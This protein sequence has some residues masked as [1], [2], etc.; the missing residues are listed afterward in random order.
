MKLPLQAR[1]IL[2]IGGSLV[3][4]QLALAWL[5]TTALAESENLRRQTL[6]A[7][8][9]SALEQTAADT[10]QQHVKQLRLTTDLAQEQASETILVYEDEEQKPKR[11]FFGR[12]FGGRAQPETPSPDST[13]VRRLSSRISD[14]VEYRNATP[15][16]WLL[17]SASAETLPPALQS[18]ARELAGGTDEHTAQLVCAD[19]ACT[20]VSVLP[21]QTTDSVRIV[22]VATTPLDEI[23]GT[24][25]R[26]GG[27]R[28]SVAQP[29]AAAAVDQTRMPFE[30]LGGVKIAPEPLQIVFTGDRG[31]QRVDDIRKQYLTLATWGV[32]LSV[33]LLA[34]LMRGV[35]K[36]VTTLSAALP[37]LTMGRFDEARQ[38][39]QRGQ[40]A[41]LARD[42]T[43]DLLDVA[44]TVTVQLSEMRSSLLRQAEALRGERDHVRLLLDTVPACVV[45]LAPDTTVQSC[46]RQMGELLG[47]PAQSLQEQALLPVIHE[48]DRAA[49]AGMV[50]QAR[51]ERS[52]IETRL[53]VDGDGPVTVH[54]HLVAMADG[55][56]LAIG[57]DVS[58]L[59]AAQR[60][61]QW[62]ADHDLQTG[63]LNRRTLTRRLS[64][65]D[66]HCT[67][68]LI[69]PGSGEHYD[70]TL[71]DNELAN[72]RTLVAKRLGQLSLAKTNIELARL[73]GLQFAALVWAPR[74]AVQAPLSK[75]FAQLRRIETTLGSQPI[76]LHMHLLGIDWP[77]GQSDELKQ[78]ILRGAMS[79]SSDSE[80]CTWPDSAAVEAACRDDYRLWVGRIDAALA[81]K[82]MTV[83]YQPIFNATTL[84]P[85][86]S[87][88]LV[89]MR[90]NAG[91]LIS[92]GM[93]M[94]H[95]EQSGQVLQIEHV[96]LEHVIDCA[97]RMQ[98][99]QQVQTLS[100]NIAARSLRD[101]A[102]YNRIVD[103]VERRGLEPQRLML[104]V[105]ESQALDDV[106][107]AAALMRRF[108]DLGVG[109][110]LDDFGIGF[111]SFEYLRELPFDYVKIDK[112]FVRQLSAS[113]DDQRLIRAIQDI[114]RGMGRKTIAEG[115]E[116]AQSLAILRD[117]GV[118]ALQGYLLSAMH[119]Q[120]SLDAVPEPKPAKNKRR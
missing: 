106:G 14:I 119:D 36:R 65:A 98:A 63:L 68:L 6:Q 30:T 72:L 29:Q 58:N 62:Q 10:A 12:L 93:F 104:E 76:S 73:Q 20:L 5:F 81:D 79:M 51:G 113:P 117:I 107:V 4:L 28:M 64:T 49:F 66:A 61:L 110:A 39:L 40:S 53:K 85:A 120:P 59:R 26:T 86:H 32:L 67:I 118:D 91:E 25:E 108:K 52:Q 116:D 45:L 71:D 96:V 41:P 56:V 31:G 34:L 57:L 27:Y 103:A 99:D 37:Q 50:E 77:T 109:I 47:R 16:L 80:A 42:E 11:G 97:L 78:Q 101:D 38:A 70:H 95:A 43:H 92:P 15:T 74:E 48:D 105:L 87:E 8:A 19:G 83:V 9:Q 69:T 2:L 18:Q 100:V 75:Q 89:R 17:K 22:A 55:Q 35:I 1:V 7:A 33:L 21:F 88:A 102:L 111:T 23:L 3:L 90:D 94:P 24:V 46:N 115:V 112:L 60:K 114:A 82:R 84:R 13:R 54:W 44:D